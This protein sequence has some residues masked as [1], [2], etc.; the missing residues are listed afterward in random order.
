MAADPKTIRD[1]EA[2]DTIH[3]RTFQVTVTFTAEQRRD[4]LR[5]MYWNEARDGPVT[6]AVRSEIISNLE[7][8]GLDASVT[9]VERMEVG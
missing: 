5:Q 6:Q 4:F 9:I 3:I 7:S 1:I 8:V 2:E